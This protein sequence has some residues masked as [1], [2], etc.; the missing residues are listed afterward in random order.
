MTRPGPLPLLLASA[1][2]RRRELLGDLG[3]R[4]EVVPPGIDEAL[5]PGLPPEAAAEAL[6]LAK[7][8][9]VAGVR[10][11]AL[12]LGADTLVAV[13]GRTLGK[14]SDRAQAR[15]YLG[16]LSGS[17]HRVVTGLA[18]GPSP[19]GPWRVGHAVTEVTM[20]RIEVAEVEAYL[21][22]GEWEGKAG[23]YA[24]QETAD[25]FVTRLEGS[26]TNVV[27]LPVE[28]LVEYLRLE[29]IAVPGEPPIARSPNAG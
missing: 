16:L 21:E 7:A 10:P 22:S 17:T 4:F 13:G 23:G 29:G 27:G 9:A 25:R 2:P 24:I 12:V 20:R 18:L 14:P 3:L 8:R 28:L 5:P 19:D 11:G 26:R 1:S 6:A 15:A